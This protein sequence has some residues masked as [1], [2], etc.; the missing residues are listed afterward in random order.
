MNKL[1][2]RINW[3]I[4]YYFVIFLYNPNKVHRYTKYMEDRWGKEW[5]IGPSDSGTRGTPGT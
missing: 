4:D 5:W 2:K 1:F 3:S